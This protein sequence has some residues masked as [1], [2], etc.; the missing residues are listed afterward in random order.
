MQND[1]SFLPKLSL[2][3]DIWEVSIGCAIW[4]DQKGWRQQDSNL[5]SPLSR[6]VARDNGVL[7][8]YILLSSLWKG[9][10][11]IRMYG[12]EIFI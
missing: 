7:S 6:P 1:F 4:T 3:L 10:C 8:I 5:E 9:Q 2:G 11:T 12:V